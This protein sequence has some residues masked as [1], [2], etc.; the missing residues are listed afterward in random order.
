VAGWSSTGVDDVSLFL[1]L[2]PGD[3]VVP[4]AGERHSPGWIP[5]GSERVRRRA[6]TAVVLAAQ[7]GELIGAGP[8][9]GT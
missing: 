8:A 4:H 2:P 7:R 5:E 1:P 6:T 9:G 3:L